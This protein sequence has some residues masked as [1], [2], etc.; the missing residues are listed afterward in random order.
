MQE[1]L[2]MMK[3]LQNQGNFVKQFITFVKNWLFIGTNKATI[4][5]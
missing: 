4:E 5:S 2:K 1:F 3:I